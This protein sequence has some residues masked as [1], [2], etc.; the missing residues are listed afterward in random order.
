[1]SAGL[2]EISAPAWIGFIAGAGNFL[3]CFAFFQSQIT[4]GG[5]T[6]TGSSGTKT[7]PVSAPLPANTHA[8]NAKRVPRSATFRAPSQRNAEHI[9]SR[10]LP[11]AD[12]GIHR[13]VAGPADS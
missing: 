5:V 7:V 2:F 3:G 11:S 13:G 8:R 9:S 10:I 4:M 1:M 12:L 6:L